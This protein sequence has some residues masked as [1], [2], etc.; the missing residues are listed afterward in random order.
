MRSAENVRLQVGDVVTRALLAGPTGEFRV[1][2]ANE[3]L[4]GAV[5]DALVA[6]AAHAEVRVDVL[7]ELELMITI[8]ATENTLKHSDEMV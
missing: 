4:A 1:A 5:D 7:V 6:D 8:K 3:G 2:R